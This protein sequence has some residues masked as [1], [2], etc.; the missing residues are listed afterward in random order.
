MLFHTTCTQDQHQHWL[1]NS[2][3]LFQMSLDKQDIETRV[4]MA[5]RDKYIYTNLKSPTLFLLNLMLRMRG[6][7]MIKEEEEEEEHQRIMH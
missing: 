3:F 5:E 1:A 2:M 4:I 7:Y 6:R